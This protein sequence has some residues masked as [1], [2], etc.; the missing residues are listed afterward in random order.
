MKRA[1]RQSVQCCIQDFVNREAFHPFSEDPT[2]SE[3]RGYHPGNFSKLAASKSPSKNCR[4]AA[5]GKKLKNLTRRLISRIILASVVNASSRQCRGLA[6]PTDR[7][8]R[9]NLCLV[10]HH[11][12][13]PFHHLKWSLH[14][15]AMPF[16]QLIFAKAIKIVAP[17]GHIFRLICTK[18]Y[19]GWGFARPRLQRSQAPSW[20]LV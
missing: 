6:T 16:T 1:K 15:L 11:L 2:G 4:A 13:L 19:Y 17:R 9:R 10:F 7:H 12:K 14:L 18:L 20:I 8:Y 5:V 3:I